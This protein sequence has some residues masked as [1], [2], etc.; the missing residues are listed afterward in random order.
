MRI[1]L[2]VLPT[3]Q[4]DLFSATQLD[5]LA[6]L[7]ELQ[8]Q[9]G[10]TPDPD[11]L[12]DLGRDADVMISSWRTPRLTAEV[13]AQCP[14]L[15]L[16]VHAA[17]SVRPVVSDALW[18]RGV[19]VSSAAAA[20]SKGVAESALGMTIASVKNHWRFAEDI[21][22]GGWS[23]ERGRV[24]ELFELT[25]G[26]IGAGNA[27]SHF[28]SLLQHF[29]VDVL[30]HDPMLSAERAADLGARPVELDTLIAASDVISLH[31]PSISATHHM[32]NARR[33]AAMKDDA[34]L[35]NTSRGS[36]IDEDA[37]I[38]ELKQGRLFACLDVTD[39]EPPAVDNPLR[40][41]PNCILTGHVAG[42]VTNG[43]RRIGNHVV[44]EIRRYLADDPLVGEITEAQLA[45]MA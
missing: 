20:L 42:A 25:V 22:A 34:I 4:D 37:L 7:G 8:I 32:I 2:A 29:D 44:A 31:A 38:H 10:A 45:T 24:R 9:R 43:K 36:L 16:L 41:L 5:Q 33:L 27:G 17:G 12:V 11:E 13:L 6:G 23:A 21:R 26:V 19:R 30:V 39:P 3:L 15:D 1:G 14:Q 35:I 28:I 40:S 18:Q